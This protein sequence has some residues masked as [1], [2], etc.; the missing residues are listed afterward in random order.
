MSSHTAILVSACV[1]TSTEHAMS[2]VD[3]ASTDNEGHLG[4][5]MLVRVT[6]MACYNNITS[7]VKF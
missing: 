5:A 4:H 3:H 2:D 7:G 1:A 6:L